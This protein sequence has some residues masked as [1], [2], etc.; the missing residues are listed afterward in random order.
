MTGLQHAS[1][2]EPD[3]TMVGGSL[4][5]GAPIVAVLGPTELAD[6]ANNQIGALPR[7]SSFAAAVAVIER[8]RSEPLTGQLN[9][10]G[11]QLRDLVNAEIEGIG[12]SQL[13]ALTGYPSI[14]RRWLAPE[15]AS[16]D[17]VDASI[18]N[19]LRLNGVLEDGSHKLCL[20]HDEFDLRQVARA[21]AEAISICWPERNQ[22][23]NQLT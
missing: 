10:L 2:L 11:L 4:A 7:A 21:Y 15:L 23:N 22:A 1:G 17:R 20:A 14:Q 3:I 5:N 16:P 13:I 6:A 8:F 12:V 19:T 18:R 9:S